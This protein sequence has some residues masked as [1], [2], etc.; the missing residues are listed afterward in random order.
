MLESG[1]Y[2]TIREL[3][4]AEKINESYLGRVLRLTLLSPNIIE[5]AC[6]VAI[7]NSRTSS[8]L[9]LL[10]GRCRN[11]FSGNREEQTRK[12]QVSGFLG[13]YDRALAH[14][15]LWKPTFLALFRSA[16]ELPAFRQAAQWLALFDF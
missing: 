15:I 9:S 7:S 3:A 8:S 6:G 4:R 13:H 2:A 10:I 5:Q 14:R 12:S 1:R 16:H 11:K